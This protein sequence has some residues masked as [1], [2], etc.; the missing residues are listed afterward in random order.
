[1]GGWLS[2]SVLSE[3][4]DQV[5]IQACKSRDEIKVNSDHLENETIELQIRMRDATFP[6]PARGKRLAFERWRGVTDLGRSKGK[7]F[8]RIHVGVVDWKAALT[9]EQRVRSVTGA[10]IAGLKMFESLTQHALPGMDRI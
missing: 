1:L 7:D 4:A 5:G 9:H 8:L 10:F 3:F 2:F 6:I